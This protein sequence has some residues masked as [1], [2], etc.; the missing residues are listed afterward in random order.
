MKCRSLVRMIC[1]GLYIVLLSACV[2]QAPLIA[3][4]DIPPVPKVIPQHLDV[5]LVLGGGGARGYAHLGVLHVLEKAG[6]P[7]DLMSGC[8]VGSIVGSLYADHPDAEWVYQ[9]MMKATFWDFA[10]IGSILSGAGM[11]SG[12]HLQQFLLDNEKANTFEKLKIPFMVAA[13]DLYTG[14]TIP[15]QSGPIAPA[16]TASAAVP[17]VVHPQ[18]LYHRTL[19][20]GGVGDPVPVDLVKRYHPKYIIAVNIGED[21]MDRMPQTSL[22]I[23]NRS[24]T[25]IWSRLSELNQAGADTVIYPAVGKSGTFD[26]SKREDMYQAGV[27]AAQKAL[28]GILKQLK[29]RGIALQ[30]PVS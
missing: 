4:P 14:A 15:L 13:T 30:K 3:V 17:G 27:V 18:Y 10:D 6:V 19:V 22:G 24:Y 25:I 20:D 21:L 12:D 23:Y 29:A 9:V 16:V 26:L 11:M 1:V 2:R 8:S 28:P 7:V 5:A